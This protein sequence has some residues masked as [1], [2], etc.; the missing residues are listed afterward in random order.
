MPVNP[1]AKQLLHMGTRAWNRWWLLLLIYVPALYV[2]YEVVI[3][4]F[5]AQNP[6]TYITV[7]VVLALSVMG[8]EGLRSRTR[9]EKISPAALDAIQQGLAGVGLPVQASI[10]VTAAPQAGARFRL[11]P[12]M[13]NVVFMP[14]PYV[15]ALPAQDLPVVAAYYLAMGRSAHAALSDFIVVKRTRM[16]TRR[17]YLHAKGKDSTRV[18]QRIDA[19]LSATNRWNEAVWERAFAD[20]VLVAG[21]TDAAI[22]ALY[23][24]AWI[25]RDFTTFAERFTRLAGKKRQVPAVLHM[26]WLETHWLRLPSW[27]GTE[28]TPEDL[29]VSFAIDGVSTDALKRI[30]EKTRAGECTAPAACRLDSKF[31]SRAA[32]RSVAGSSLRAREDSRINA[33]DV[34]AP[35]AEDAFLLASA[36]EA[37]GRTATRTDVLDMLVGGRTAPLAAA[38]LGRELRPEDEAEPDYGLPRGYLLAALLTGAQRERG[39]QKRD[40]YRDRLLTAP[41]GR[42]FDVAEV[43]TTALAS[44]EGMKRLRE[45]LA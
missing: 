16:W 40:I 12:W 30:A 26:K 14:L 25:T 9:L 38:I 43:V 32:V 3:G 1:S 37:L 41:D 33:E 8:V 34:Y 13:R 21:G 42:I 36:S 15:L 31:A 20:A 24:A 44:R 11:R 19:Y 45:L 28:A 22:A 35:V 5:T 2:D 6:F 10:F 7:A 17:A 27:E 23:R 4:R 18:A 39:F 29:D